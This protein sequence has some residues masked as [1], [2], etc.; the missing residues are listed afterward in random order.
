[1]PRRNTTPKLRNKK[2]GT[3]ACWFTKAGNSKSGETY[4]G[5]VDL[6]PFKEA[7]KLRERPVSVRSAD[8]SE[9]DTNQDWRLCYHGTS[10]D[11]RRKK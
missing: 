2:I 7:R 6:V 11:Y 10:L 8:A 1:M 3:S 4:F 9:C 5:N